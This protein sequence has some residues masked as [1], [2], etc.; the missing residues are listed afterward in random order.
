M[1]CK[2]DKIVELNQWVTAVILYLNSVYDDRAVQLRKAG[3]KY[4]QVDFLRSLYDITPAAVSVNEPNT[5]PAP[6]ESSPEPA[7]ATPLN[8]QTPTPVATNDE[9]LPMPDATQSAHDAIRMSHDEY[10]R[11]ATPTL[12]ESP[13]ASA[14]L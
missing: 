2:V 8:D 14:E 5:K 1:S 11:I 7:S 12:F 4:L 10:L 13:C 9:Q 3:A 6:M